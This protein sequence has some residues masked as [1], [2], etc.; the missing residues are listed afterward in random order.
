[1]VTVLKSQNM[2]LTSA[3]FEHA[4]K[5]NFGYRKLS[6]THRFSLIDQY[7]SLTQRNVYEC[8][9]ISLVHLYMRVANHDCLLL[10]CDLHL[11]NYSASVHSSNHII[12]LVGWK[13]LN[14]QDFTSI[15]S[16]LSINIL[17]NTIITQIKKLLNQVHLQ[18]LHCEYFEC[19]WSTNWTNEELR[20]ANEQ[21]WIANALVHKVLSINAWYTNFTATSWLL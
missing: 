5:S 19:S 1:M 20:I 9:H 3:V 14:L 16:E 4:S 7:T 11:V 17:L 10:L 6:C 8:I 18:M 13:Q 12:V 2:L 21:L 15:I